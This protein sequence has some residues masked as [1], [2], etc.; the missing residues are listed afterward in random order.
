M[1]SPL[2]T[3][4]NMKR[5]LRPSLRRLVPEHPAALAALDIAL[6]SLP[7]SII[8]HS[9]R[10]F[11]YAKAMNASMTEDSLPTS[12]VKP[13]RIADH[14]LFVACI[15]HD[16]EITEKYGSIARRFE[17]TSADEAANLLR[18]NGVDEDLI[19]EAWLAISL[20]SSPGIAECL[21]G[22]VGAMRKAIMAEFGA[23]DVPANELSEEERELL[24]DGQDL[25]RLDIEAELGDAIVRQCR[26]TR[27]KAPSAS[28]PG[29]MLRAFEQDTEHVGANKAFWDCS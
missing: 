29:V 14:V 17:V 28:W 19:R 2:D 5:L 1:S 24:L 11:L 8:N 10:V 3:E 9:F 22:T 12:P 15:L 26:K 7:Q 27:T 20:H 21:P 13:I 4:A 6:S 23:M 25:E 16:I 18:S